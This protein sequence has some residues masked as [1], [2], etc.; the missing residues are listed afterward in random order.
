MKK[1]IGF[2]AKLKLP[3]IVRE[4]ENKE[5]L[6]LRDHLALERT[7]LA[8][9][10]TFLSYIRTSLYLVLGGFALINLKETENLKWLGYLAL[11]LS[12]MFILFG[13][14]RFFL[15]RKRLEKYYRE[16]EERLKQK[17]SEV[18]G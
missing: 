16:R 5:D 6:I 8:N 12:I 10:R 9:E 18:S 15:L 1:K 7:R 13:V 2:P 17:A 4:Y 14:V 11:G 3:A